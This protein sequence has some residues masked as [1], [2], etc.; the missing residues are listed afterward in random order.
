MR[1]RF[2]RGTITYPPATHDVVDV[3]AQRLGLS[4]V[5]S[6]NAERVIR[7]EFSP[8]VVLKFIS[9]GVAEDETAN[10]G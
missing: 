1:E 3:V 4:T 6:A 2:V 10:L 8:F 7:K 5:A 9:K